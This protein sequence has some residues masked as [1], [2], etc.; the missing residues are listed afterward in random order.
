MTRRAHWQTHPP[1]PRPDAGGRPP[2][3]SHPAT[4]SGPILDVVAAHLR[5]AGVTGT[6]LDPFAGEGGIHELRDRAGVHTIGVEIEPEWAATHPDTRVGNALELGTTFAPGSIDAIVT[7]PTY[8]NRMADHHDA[9]D[10]SVR[11]TY[12]HTLGHD[13]HEDNSGQMQWGDEYRRFHETAWAE[14]E[15]ALKPGGTL[16]LN[17]KNHIRDGQVQRVAEWHIDTLYGLGLHLTQMDMVPTSGLMAGANADKRT[18]A[19]YV[20][21]FRKDRS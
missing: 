20:L 17:I 9:K 8:G 21:T 3:K 15:G 11:L 1:S 4:F 10:D 2:Q 18:Q 12:K 19:E 5:E 6:V 13:L 7:S 14:A 16:T